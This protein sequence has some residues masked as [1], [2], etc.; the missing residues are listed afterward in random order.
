MAGSFVRSPTSLAPEFALVAWRHARVSTIPGSSARQTAR[1]G[2]LGWEQRDRRQREPRRNLTDDPNCGT[3]AGSRERCSGWPCPVGE[4]RRRRF[5]V[6][7]WH[8]QAEHAARV[9]E[10]GSRVVAVGWLQ[11]QTWTAEDDSAQ[12]VIEVVAQEPAPSLT[13]PPQG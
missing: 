10:P 5:T 6:V 2:N 1:P 12:Q 3:E 11:Q 13:G 4:S 8:D 7:V 9:A